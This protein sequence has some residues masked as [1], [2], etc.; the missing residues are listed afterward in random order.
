M[1]GQASAAT[2]G[3]DTPM[4]RITEFCRRC[5]DDVK[6]HAGICPDCK[7]II[8]HAQKQIEDHRNSAH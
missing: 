8:A 1:S 3:R 6:H 4:K 2:E 7:R 5:G